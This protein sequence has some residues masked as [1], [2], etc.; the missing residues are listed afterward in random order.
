MAGFRSS[1]EVT[2]EA[3]QCS[4][5]GYDDMLGLWTIGHLA[6]NARATL[7][8][9]VRVTGS[10]SITNTAAIIDNHY[11]TV[12]AG[13]NL[14]LSIGGSQDIVDDFAVEMTLI[15]PNANE[16]ETSTSRIS[17]TTS[18]ADQ[19]IVAVKA[20]NGTDVGFYKLDG[21]PLTRYVA[22]GGSDAGNEP[23]R[24][25]PAPRL[26]MPSARPTTAISLTWRQEP[27][28]SRGLLSR[29]N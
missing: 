17:L 14:T 28:P 6:L 20:V 10:G 5:C 7:N 1:A 29:K 25:V 2:S 13:F 22:P 3:G 16:L 21:T 4:T 15:D 27:T 26:A 9:K 23:I 24:G 8:I 11:F 12:G 18:E 19:Y